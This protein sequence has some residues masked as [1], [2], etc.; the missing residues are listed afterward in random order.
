[1]ATAWGIKFL[2]F[3]SGKLEF[4]LFYIGN[5]DT[6][7]IHFQPSSWKVMAGIIIMVSILCRDTKRCQGIEVTSYTILTVPEELYDVGLIT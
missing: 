2:D 5:G 7:Q 6:L 4:S 1:M 3:Y